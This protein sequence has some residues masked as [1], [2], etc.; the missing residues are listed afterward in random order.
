MPKFK[1]FKLN[2]DNYRYVILNINHYLLFLIE[3]ND[4]QM[5]NL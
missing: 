3:L 2:I 4:I 1:L 5:I